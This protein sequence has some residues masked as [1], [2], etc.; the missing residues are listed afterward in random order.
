M[1]ATDKAS[2]KAL[3][4][5]TVACKLPHGIHMDLR[6]PINLKDPNN[7]GGNT[8]VS[9]VTLNGSA[10]GEANQ[11]YGEAGF[12]LTFN[13]PKEHFEQWLKDHEN[14]PAV[15]NGLI[16]AHR[17]Q[18]SVEAMA[19][20]NEGKKSGLEP[21]DPNDKKANGVEKMSKE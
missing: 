20:E 16:F 13:V 14:H 18:A 7:P 10:K 12:G 21:V 5:V 11:R 17:E 19:R 6:T 15:K 2:D 8:L 4:T 3:E 1:A 9:R